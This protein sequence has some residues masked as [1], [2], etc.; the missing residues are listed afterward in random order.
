MMR[1]KG[2]NLLRFYPNFTV[3]DMETTGRSNHFKDITEISAI[4]YRN[5]QK[6]ASFSTLVK[7]ENS[8]LPY[9]V[10]LT[11]ISDEM[12]QEAPRIDQVIK[13][14]VQFIGEDIILGHNV[15][16]D[17]NLIYDA[18]NYK[19]NKIIDNNYVDT[20][21]ISRLMNN[22]AKNHKLETLCHYFDVPR[23]FGHRGLVDCE[24]TAQIYIKMKEKYKIIIEGRRE[25]ERI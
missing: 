10:G 9:V 5:Y 16:F 21:R 7:A 19:T 14:F 8:I 2:E 17:L 25:D 20:L 12:I 23:D 18:F 15:N 1:K 22:D 4:R 24:Q 6:V 13:E 11:G 3:I